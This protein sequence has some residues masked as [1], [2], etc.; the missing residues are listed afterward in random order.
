MRR[1]HLVVHGVSYLE[2]RRRLG[3]PSKYDEEVF[4]PVVSGEEQEFNAAVWR[5]EHAEDK[6]EMSLENRRQCRQIYR[7]NIKALESE[8][9][10]QARRPGRVRT[11]EIGDDRDD[12]HKLD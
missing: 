6:D 8:E 7:A 11:A 1:H 5:E 2:A 9:Q 3:A 10:R 4:V 12:D